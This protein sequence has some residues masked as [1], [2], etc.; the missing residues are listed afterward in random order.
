MRSHVPNSGTRSW[1]LIRLMY[2]TIVIYTVLNM[3]MAC[4]DKYLPDQF[5]I[6]FFGVFV[7]QFINLASIKKKKIKKGECEDEDIN[8]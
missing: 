5:H 6:G 2:V 1:L 3:V 4:F 7:I 8:Q